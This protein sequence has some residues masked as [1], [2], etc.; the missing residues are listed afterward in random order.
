MAYFSKSR[1]CTWSTSQTFAEN[2][3]IWCMGVVFLERAA[4][5]RKND[6]FATILKVTL[7]N[8]ICLF[9]SELLWNGWAL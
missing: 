6:I 8:I 9:K 3:Y 1:P 4:G 5:S 2:V 7:L